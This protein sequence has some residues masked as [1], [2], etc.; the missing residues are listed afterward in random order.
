M[1]RPQSVCP[2]QDDGRRR[3]V[4]IQ[5]AAAVAAVHTIGQD[6]GDN[7]SAS[8]AGLTCSA[9]ID[10]VHPNTGTCSLVVD[11]VPKLAPCGVVNGF[12]EHRPGQAVDAQIFQGDDGVVLHQG[13]G[14]LMKKVAAL[15]GGV[16]AVTRQ[17]ALRR[18]PAPAASLGAGKRT[19]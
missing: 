7:G 19:L 11:E 1:S 6:F 10:D 5:H 4:A 3:T 8:R 17:P 15:V 13:A 18:E 12:G 16:G 9:Q 14:Q 2:L